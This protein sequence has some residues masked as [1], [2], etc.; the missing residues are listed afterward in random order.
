[1]SYSTNPPRVKSFIVANLASS[2]HYLVMP[3]ARLPYESYDSLRDRSTN[4]RFEE[5]VDRSQSR[6]PDG[7][8]AKPPFREQSRKHVLGASEHPSP[9]KK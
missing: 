1:M 3:S 5:S 4:L 8:A 7:Q 9:T 6:R 2:I